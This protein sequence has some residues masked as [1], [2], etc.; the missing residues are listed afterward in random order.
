MSITP[1]KFVP[2]EMKTTLVRVYSYENKTLQGTISNPFFE[3]AIVFENVMQFITILEFLSDSLVYPQKAMELR[4]FDHGKEEKNGF[5]F[6]TSADFS[7]KYPLATFE[8]EILFRQNA[9]WQGKVTYAEQGSS[10]AFRSALEL[11]MLMD[12]A[13][14]E[15]N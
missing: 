6:T 7:E 8:V 14:S 9:S 4:Q 3:A 15:A 2:Y 10:A 13:L 5:G 11:L 12:S 1:V